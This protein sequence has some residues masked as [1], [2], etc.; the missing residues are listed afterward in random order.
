MAQKKYVS[1]E[2]LGLYHE[3][4]VARVNGL[5]ST[6][7]TEANAYADSLAKNYDAAGMA[8]TEAGKVQTKL[9][10]EVTRAKAA[11]EA[12][13][14]AAKKAQDD[15]IALAGKVGEV[16]EGSTVVGMIDAVDAIADAN[17]ADIVTMK[18]QID[19]LEKGTY[20]DTE[21]RGLIQDNADAIDALEGVHADDKAELEGKINAKADQTALDG[22]SAVANAAVKQ[23]DYDVKVKALE[24]EDARIVGLVEAEAERAAGVEA[25]HEERLVE[26]EA[27]FKL[28]E[29]EQ[30][31]TAL[32][33]LKEIQD[34]VTG[35]GAAADKMVEDIAA[36]KKLIEDHIA[37]DHDFAGADAALKAELEGK[38]NAKADN[39][40]LTELAGKVTTAEG[41]IDTLQTDLGKAQSDIEALQTA[42]GDGGSVEDMID[43]AIETAMGEEETRVDGL[44]NGKVDKVDGKGLSTN[45]LTNELKAQYDAAYAHS[46]VA[47]APADAQKNVI[48]TVK[49]NGV[50]LTVADKAVDVAVPT[51]NAQLANGAGYLVAADVANKADKATTLAGYGIADAY[52]SAQ[53]DAAIATAMEQL[54]ECGEQDIIDIFA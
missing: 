33:T 23:A 31:D 42:V 6:A 13:A 4:E 15:V 24:D 39:S 28:A 16:A 5:I 19:A 25:D 12:N 27:F 30:L 34:Y 9:D 37:T 54:V 18:G 10:E 38:I 14:A 49:V 21:V 8:V 29:G 2:K 50:A 3:K 17:A 26:V 52:T 22:V 36:N 45:D 32:D 51:D 35:E 47:H 46:Q 40:A 43:A 53:T 1:I 11:E 7:K 44:L 48:E 41:E 20:D